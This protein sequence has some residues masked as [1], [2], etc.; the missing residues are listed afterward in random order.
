MTPSLPFSPSEARHPWHGWAFRL[1]AVKMARKNPKQPEKIG[2]GVPTALFSY[3]EWS[4]YLGG[5]IHP[6]PVP[7]QRKV[8]SP[9]KML[10][11]TTHAVPMVQQKPQKFIP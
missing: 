7:H 6:A 5:R 4:I 2:T 3:Y 1:D 8:E 10:R 11:K 9:T